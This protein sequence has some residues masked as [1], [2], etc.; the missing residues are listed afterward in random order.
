MNEE[1]N[2]IV[3][4]SRSNRLWSLMGGVAPAT[5]F[6][7]IMHDADELISIFYLGLDAVSAAVLLF[8]RFCCRS[9]WIG[10]CKASSSIGKDQKTTNEG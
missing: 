3:S 9:N 4:F 8:E 10:S 1:E 5:H 6:L 7:L 2:P